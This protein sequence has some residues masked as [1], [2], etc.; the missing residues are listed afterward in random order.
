MM[1]RSSKAH[2]AQVGET[3]FRMRLPCLSERW[4]SVLALLAWSTHW[5]QLY[6]IRLAAVQ[7]LHCQACSQTVANW[8]PSPPRTL[9]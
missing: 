8:K 3:Y 6:V 1:L 4:R 7:W 9:Q 5:S 2:L